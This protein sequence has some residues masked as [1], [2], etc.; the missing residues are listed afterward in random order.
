MSESGDDGATPAV[1]GFLRRGE[2]GIYYVR[3]VDG[4]SAHHL[5]VWHMHHASGQPATIL[6]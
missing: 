3:L 2:I 1:V 6:W 5:A 4:S